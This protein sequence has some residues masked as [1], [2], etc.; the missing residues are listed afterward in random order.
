MDEV[1]VKV[2]RKGRKCKYLVSNPRK[3]FPAPFRPT[4]YREPFIHPFSVLA[5]NRHRNSSQLTPPDTSI[6][7]F[8]FHLLPQPQNQSNAALEFRP[9]LL[10]YRNLY[11]VIP[12]QSSWPPTSQPQPQAQT[13]R[14][15]HSPP[16]PS[17][18]HAPRVSITITSIKAARTHIVAQLPRLES[19]CAMLVCP[20]PYISPIY[21]PPICAAPPTQR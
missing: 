21:R 10:Q 11:H 13:P 15:R 8:T 7:L 4:S 2:L 3:C 12:T 17:L 19:D 6:Q 14:H 5:L 20:S 16:P 18:R 9:S 1:S